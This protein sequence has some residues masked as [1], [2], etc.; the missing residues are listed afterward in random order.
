M[1]QIHLC[2]DKTKAMLCVQYN[3]LIS[4]LLMLNTLH[5]LPGCKVRELLNSCRL[6]D[7]LL[8]KFMGMMVV[9]KEAEQSE[10][11][12]WLFRDISCDAETR[13]NK[14]KCCRDDDEEEAGW[15]LHDGAAMEKGIGPNGLKQC[16][17]IKEP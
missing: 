12:C 5:V 16:S 6:E 8:K 2:A 4:A 3:M 11:E 10:L 1:A 13:Q 9:W 7:I 14:D 17:R 15:H